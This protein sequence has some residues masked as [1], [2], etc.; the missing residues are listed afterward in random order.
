MGKIPNKTII[1]DWDGWFQTKY[2]NDNLGLL[3]PDLTVMF[4]RLG[5]NA[6]ISRDRKTLQQRFRNL[7]SLKRI[8]TGGERVH[9]RV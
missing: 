2:L 3:R 9:T 4:L 6:A 1:T 7:F 5:K 8:I